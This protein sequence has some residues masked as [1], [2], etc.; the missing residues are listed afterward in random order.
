MFGYVR[1]YKPEMKIKHYEA[2]RG[3]YC[4]VCR[5]LGKNYGPLSR[6]IL[7]YDVT[8]LALMRIAVSGSEPCFVNKRCPFNPAKK[9]HYCTNKSEQLNYAAAVGVLLVYYKLLDNLRD[10]GFFGRAGAALLFP[11]MYFAARRAKKRYPDIAAAADEA[12]QRQA[13]LEKSRCAKVDEAAQPM[14]KLLELLFSHGIGG[15]D[16]LALARLGYCLGRWVYIMDA[17]EDI[18][19]DI[20]RSGYNVFVLS[21]DIG[22]RDSEKI[23]QARAAALPMLNLC[24]AEAVKAYEL[25]DCGALKPVCENILYDGLY[26]SML[27]VLKFENSSEELH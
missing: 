26:N 16:G 2:Y 21:G 5:A 11:Y 27:S 24:C 15:N 7:S 9:C 8:M 3:L 12:M 6:M 14:A 4:S 25:C 20:K 18:E 19:K 23:A 1:A 13:E 17:A 10:E 22:A